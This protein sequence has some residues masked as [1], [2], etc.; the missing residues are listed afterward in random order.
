MTFNTIKQ[1][2]IKYLIK[3]GDILL[4]NGKYKDTLVS[5]LLDTKDGFHYIRY[6]VNNHYVSD[7]FM[8]A[9]INL[10]AWSEE[11]ENRNTLD[12]ETPWMVDPQHDKK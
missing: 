4:L 11:E 2:T 8:A 9:L 5:E 3:D 7:E 6:V 12:D 10:A 1:Q